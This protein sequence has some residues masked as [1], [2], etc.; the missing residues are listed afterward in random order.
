[1]QYE[2]IR[3]KRKTVSLEIKSGGRIIVRAPERMKK[4]D[5]E[6]FVSE[7]TPWI[8]KHLKRL[9]EAEK[10]VSAK[11]LTPD[12]ISLLKKRA[13]DYIPKRA[14]YYSR[15]LGVEYKSITIRCQKTKWGSC[16]SKGNLNFN[17]LLMLAPKEVI[18]SV[19]VHELCHLKHMN[20]SK[21]FYN[22]VLS[23][24]PEYKKYNSWLKAN[25]PAIMARRPN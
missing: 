17:C 21:S 2:L 6:S 15:L 19:I 16:S 18:D 11:P 12:E 5:I 25:G 9:E 22:E 1:M 14:E 10:R 8:E 4:R 3:S 20:H 24:F 13:K 23:V 7:K